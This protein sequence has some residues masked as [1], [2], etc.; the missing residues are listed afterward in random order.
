MI[1]HSRRSFL[2]TSMRAAAGM[3]SSLSV[4]RLLPAGQFAGRIKKAVKYHMVTENLSAKDKLKLLQDL[5]F[6]GVEPRAMLDPRDRDKVKELREASE[7]LNFPI[8][9]VVN[10]SNPNIVGAIEQAKYFGASSIL[11]VVGYDQSISYQQNYAQ[12]QTIIRKA[13]DHAERNEIY[14]LIENVWATF[15][16]E[17]MSMVRYIDEI[18]SPFVQVYFDIGN[19]VRWGWPQH[20]LEILGKRAKKLD[21]KEYDLDVAMKEGM[22]QGFDKP[23]GQG[24]ID[25]SKVRAELTKIDYRGWAAAEVKGGDRSRLK[26]IAEQMDR[27]LDL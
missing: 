5:G 12:T 21:V 25:W 1:P 15:L 14:I 20:W 10:S 2:K 13:V 27:V 17:P 16:I 18:G 23:L 9:G 8:H 7:S 19:V 3:G 6:D 22:R 24:S 11:H 26:E 4:A